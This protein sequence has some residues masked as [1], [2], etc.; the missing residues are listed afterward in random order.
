MLDLYVIFIEMKE[1]G[2]TNKIDHKKRMEEW[3]KY[4]IQKMTNKVTVAIV[5]LYFNYANETLIANYVEDNIADFIQRSKK[6]SYFVL[7]CK[8][9]Q[10]PNRVLSVRLLI[11]MFYKV[12]E[13][14]RDD[15]VDPDLYQTDIGGLA[16]IKD[17]EEKGLLDDEIKPK[18][19]EKKKDEK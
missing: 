11:S 4:I 7:T 10:Y 16:D 19:T 5:P 12:T 13:N 15:T 1:A 2:L 9:F 3:R 18:E 17:E 8:I 6:D 14:E